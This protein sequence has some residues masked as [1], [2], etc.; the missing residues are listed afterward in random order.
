MRGHY[1]YVAHDC[2]SFKA[3]FTYCCRYYYYYHYYHYYHYYYSYCDCN[4]NC[5]Y[6]CYDY[7]Y[8]DYDDDYCSTTSL[9]QA[10]V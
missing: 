8:Y 2:L 4:C 6:D 7:D 5:D 10:P 3:P 1:T 9:L